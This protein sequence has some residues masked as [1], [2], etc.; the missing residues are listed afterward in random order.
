[1]IFGVPPEPAAILPSRQQDTGAAARSRPTVPR[2]PLLLVLLGVALAG[3][4]GLLLGA[5]VAAA[6]VVLRLRLLVAD[7]ADADLSIRWLGRRSPAPVLP[8]FT[9]TVGSVE[10]GLVS[11]FDFDTALRPRLARV[12][13]ARLADG[14]GIDVLARPDLAMQVLGGEEWALIDPARAPAADR[15]TPGPDRAALRRVLDA[16]E[17]V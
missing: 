6:L 10:W 14:R 4:A 12:A 16:I 7:P 5:T 8:G 2:W 3:P 17:Q 15:S 11:A 1:M 13:A 9:R